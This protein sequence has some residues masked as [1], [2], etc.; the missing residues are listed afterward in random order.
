M[1]TKTKAMRHDW[2]NYRTSPERRMAHTLLG[3]DW[4]W[5]QALLR[6]GARLAKASRRTACP[7]STNPW[8]RCTL[9]HHR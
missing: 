2:G 4:P 5:I 7:A 6:D 1:S 9:S 3:A 8:T